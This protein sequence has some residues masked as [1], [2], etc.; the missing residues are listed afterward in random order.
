MVGRD[1]KQQK[2]RP[3]RECRQVAESQEG[4]GRQLLSVAV[5]EGAEE[6]GDG[7]YAWPPAARLSIMNSE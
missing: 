4:N 3:S 1:G 5:G 6:G 2:R 7:A